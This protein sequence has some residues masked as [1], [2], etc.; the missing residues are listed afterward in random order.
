M[1]AGAGFEPATF[2][3]SLIHISP[4]GPLDYYLIYGP[5]AKQVVESYAWLT[6]PT[7]LPPLWSLGYQQSRYSYY[8]EE[9]VREIA[10]RLRADRIPADAIYLDIDYQQNN[11]PFTVNRERFPT[12]E[13]MIKDLSSQQLHVV[14]ITDLHIAKLPNAGYAPYD[15]GL[16][17]DHFVK[18]PDGSV[19]VAKVW[20]GDSVFPDFT[21]QQTRAWWGSLY[22]EDVYKRQII[23]QLIGRKVFI[24]RISND[25]EMAMS[26][27][28]VATRASF[29]RV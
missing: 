16:A 11:R 8:P 29:S 22:K 7:P 14:A 1:V 10:D 24:R 19:Y 20:P 27:L 17:G 13:Q 9:K 3:L 2:G 4:D 12:F 5:T 26:R 6:G 23:L 21:R 18:N 15:S 25:I 28:T